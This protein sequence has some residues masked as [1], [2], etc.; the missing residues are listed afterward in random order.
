MSGIMG[1]DEFWAHQRRH[2]STAGL[3]RSIAHFNHMLGT[4]RPI[5]A[6]LQRAYLQCDKC[7]WRG[8][9][10]SVTICPKCKSTH[11][12]EISHIDLSDYSC[13]SG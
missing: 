13:C 7:Q 9:D 5:D 2:N 10:L 3:K 1:N 6:P 8:Y 11:L 12:S 4:P